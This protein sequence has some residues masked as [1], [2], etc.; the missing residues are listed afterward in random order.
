MTIQ[1]LY[2]LG[3]EMAI[4]ADPRGESGVKKFLDR[5]KKKY[6]KLPDKDKKYFDKESLKNPYSDSRIL[7]GSPSKDVKKI[8]AGID[9]NASEVLLVDRLNQKG[10]GID[11]LLTHH[12]EGHALAALHEVM[13]LQVEMYG[14]YGISENVSA[15]LMQDRMSEMQRRLSPLNHNQAIDAARLLDIPLMA[16]HTIW[17]N[18]A[19]N[20]MKDYLKK[21]QFDYL[22]DLY[23]YVLE[24]PE[25]KEARIGKA[26]PSIVS[27]TPSSRVGKVASFF[28]G[29]SNPSTELYIEAAKAG[30]GTIIEMHIK[31]DTLTEL[32]K[33]HVNVIDCGHMA[34]DSIGANIYLDEVEKKGIEILP[35]AGLIRVK[36]S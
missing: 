4:K 9:G 10:A 33:L 17:D 15:A 8:F 11:L 31:E 34:A 13:D 26:A 28:T 2:D 32:R 19:Y 5:Q 24:I 21:Q 3:I 16:L 14:E 23:E 36:R 18:I 6:D 30:I 29:G 12:P 1:Q 25:F 22:G 7:Y 27:G 20:F 35:G